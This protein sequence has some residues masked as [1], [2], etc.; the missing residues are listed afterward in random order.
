[1]A[2]EISCGNIDCENNIGKQSPGAT[3]SE[4]PRCGADM[5]RIA[6]GKTGYRGANR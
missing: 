2:T 6:P 4:N 5:I 3:G 1:M